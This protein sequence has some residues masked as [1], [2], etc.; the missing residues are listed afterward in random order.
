MFALS[1]N[2][3]I[4]AIY[5]EVNSKNEIKKELYFLVS[6]FSKDGEKETHS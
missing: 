2:P 4:K 5:S 1:G 3:K 6:V